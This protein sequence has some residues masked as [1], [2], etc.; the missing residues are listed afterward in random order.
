MLSMLI[1]AQESSFD[2]LGEIKPFCF[3]FDKTVYSIVKLFS[4]FQFISFVWSSAKFLGNKNKIKVIIV[5]LNKIKNRVIK[6]LIYNYNAYF[7]LLSTVFN[8]KKCTISF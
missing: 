1:H 4:L 6:K 7:I 3:L 5:I 8:Y 2:S